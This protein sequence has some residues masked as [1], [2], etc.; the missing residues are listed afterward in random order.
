MYFSL[1]ELKIS[2]SSFYN[3]YW[4]SDGF[5]NILWIYLPSSVLQFYYIYVCMHACVCIHVHMPTCIHQQH[6]CGGQSTTMWLPGIE[7]RLS[8]NAVAKKTTLGVIRFISSYN[9]A[10][11]VLRN[12]QG[13]KWSRGYGGILTSLLLKARSWLVQ[14]AFLPAPGSPAQ[15]GTAHSMHINH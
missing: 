7:L 4:H 15:D 10:I 2:N 1:H 12:Q 5:P 8:A 3:F 14:P 9:S 6:S 13:R 11:T